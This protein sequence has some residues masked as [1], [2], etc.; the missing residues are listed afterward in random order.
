MTTDSHVRAAIYCRI[1]LSRIGDTT[2]VEDQERICRGLA[3]RRGWEVAEVY[4]DNSQSAWKKNR[5]RPAWDRMVADAEAG[6]VSAIIVYHGDRLIRRPED[7]FRLLKFAR[8]RGLKLASPVGERDLGNTDDEFVLWIEAAMANKESGNLSRR[9]EAEYARLRRKGLVRPGGRGGRAFGFATDGVTHVPDECAVVRDAARRVLLGESTGSIARS[10]TMLTPAGSQMSDGT[11]RNMLARPRYAGLMPDGIHEA[12][13]APVLDR[14]EWE[15]VCATLDAKAFAFGYATNARRWLLSGIALC[16]ECWTP[17]QILYSKGGKRSKNKVTGYGC[18]RPGCRKVYRSAALLDAYVTG[19][20]VGRLSHP[21][22]PAVEVQLHDGAAAEL[23]ALTKRRAET[24]AF[25]A[26]LADAPAG[27]IEVLSRALD[28]FDA[29][30]EAI[31]AQ[32]AGDSAGRLRASHAGI[33]PDEFAALP[34]DVRR[35][36]VQGTYRVV[37]LRASGRGPGFRPQDVVLSPV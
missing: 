17:L 30:I 22:N 6:K 27:R 35:A 24:E 7:L 23:A 20:V 28:S 1:S 18:K 3:E 19:A 21:D 15:M 12:A 2:K 33:T 8:E 34:L 36:L 11:L 16:G 32:M 29:K 4:T 13:W 10:V 14:A 5:K 26:S 9:K 25:I 31:R 37:V